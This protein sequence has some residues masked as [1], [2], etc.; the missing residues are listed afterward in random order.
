MGNYF[1][2]G[3]GQAERD[4][5]DCL[6]SVAKLVKNGEQGYW[7]LR[8]GYCLSK[9]VGSLPRLGQWIGD[10]A[11]RAESVRAEVQV[12]IHWDTEVHGAEHGVCQVLCSALPI[13]LNRGSDNPSGLE[14][15]ARIVLAAAYDAT[16]TA[17]ALLATQRGAR[18]RVFLTCIGA[19]TLG[20][21]KKWIVEAL[22]QALTKHQHEPL[23]VMLVH[24]ATLDGQRDYEKLEQGRSGVSLVGTMKPKGKVDKNK[25]PKEIQDALNEMS[26]SVCSTGTYKLDGKHQAYERF[27]ANDDGQIDSEELADI[28]QWAQSNTAKVVKAF[29]NADRNGDGV[30]DRLE[31]AR[32]LQEADPEVFTQKNIDILLAEADSDADGEV[33][34]VEFFTWLFGEDSDVVQMLLSGS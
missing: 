24:F 4:E 1:V 20:N 18:V 9:T 11:G 12:G 21:R 31:F 26:E 34:Y 15:F 16:L 32:F 10:G 3:C 25:G 23:D 7:T 22:D 33:H 8:N 30:L 5:I 14:V 13:S 2:N 17:A 27:D 29:G 28:E 6:G 19:G